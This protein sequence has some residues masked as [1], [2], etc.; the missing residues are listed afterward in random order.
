MYFIVFIVD[1]RTQ[2]HLHSAYFCS[3]F[4]FSFSFSFFVASFVSQFILFLKMDCMDS[5]N[6]LLQ[7]YVLE[8]IP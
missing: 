1:D 6:S 5:F 3:Q 2:S 7:K 8:P 4:L